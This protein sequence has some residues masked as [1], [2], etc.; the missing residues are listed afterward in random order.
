V[1]HEPEVLAHHFTQANLYVR[2]VP[3]WVQAG[4]RALAKVALPE[5][6]GH[7]SAALKLNELLPAGIE[8]DRQELD[9][10]LLLGAAYLASLGWAAIEVVRTLGPARDL[11]VRLR[12]DD[13]LVAILFYTWFHHM[14][15]C[16][17]PRTCE[18]AAELRALAQ[19]RGDSTTTVIAGMAQALLCWFTG[20]PLQARAAAEAMLAAYDPEQHGQLAL[21]YIHDPKCLTLAWAAEWLWAL[22]YPEQAQRAAEEQLRL[23][24]QLRHP[25]NLFV[26]LSVGT[27]GLTACGETRLAREWLR[28][29]KV[30]AKD[31]GMTFMAEAIVP[32][33]DGCAL[34]A[35]GEHEL[36]DATLAVGAKGW[37]DTGPLH[38]I[39]LANLMRARALT[40]LSQFDEARRL[41]DEAVCI[42]DRTGHRSH[43]P[44]VHR[45]LGEL[46]QRQP[47]SDP[48]A[49]ERCF[50]RALEAARAQDA[51]GYEL[52]VAASLARLWQTQGRREDARELLQSAYSWFTEGFDTKD[53]T[54]ARALI[55]AL[56]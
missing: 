32:F 51:K 34:I 33:W 3:C 47:A 29:A 37:R 5:A 54:E 12:E 31:L 36:G 14:M 15:R 43:E 7:L 41:L 21:T 18:I 38:L 42:I 50:L 48:V 20:D 9:I 10:R 17:Y 49:A 39:P 40:A 46:H 19:S 45:V 26:S 6:V 44:E 28:E 27:V 4:Q 24:R 55:G 2:A 23:A 1:E 16:E 13:K 11:A 35:A 56:S 52:R 8:R 25:M 22:G 30:L 53:L